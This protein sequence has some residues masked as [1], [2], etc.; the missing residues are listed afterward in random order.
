MVAKVLGVD[1]RL[2]ALDAHEPALAA[3]RSAN[4]SLHVEIA[5][6][7]LSADWTRNAAG[8]LASMIGAF[9]RS[10]HLLAAQTTL[11]HVSV[12]VQPVMF[13]ELPAADEP[14]PAYLALER[15]IT[16]VGSTVDG[17]QVGAHER[18][19]ADVASKRLRDGLEAVK[20][21]EV[22]SHTAFHG[23]CLSAGRARHSTARLSDGG[24]P[25]LVCPSSVVLTD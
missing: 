24:L 19:T 23:E 14:S 22:R 3:M 25:E 13:V 17:Q 1:E 4:M 18:L 2:A 16:G 10:F 9:S 15:S 7:V 8:V 6:E 5:G 20:S 12:D 11:V 21:G